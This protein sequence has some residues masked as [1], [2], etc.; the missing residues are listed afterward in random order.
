MNDTKSKVIGDVVLVQPAM[1]PWPSFT[2]RLGGFMLFIYVRWTCW[3]LGIEMLGA[4]A[5]IYIGPCFV[6]MCHINRQ[7]KCFETPHDPA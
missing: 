4:G 2:Q 6:G 7:R 3:G 5:A 1:E